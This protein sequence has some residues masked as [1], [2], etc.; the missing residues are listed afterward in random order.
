MP[1]RQKLRNPKWHQ[2]GLTLLESLIALLVSAL[3][4]LGVIGVQMRTLS[5]TQTSVRR[6]QSIRMIEDLSERM[7]VNPNAMANMSKYVSDWSSSLPTPEA[8][9]NCAKVVCT[10]S[11][12]AAYDLAEWKRFVQ[13]ALPS[14]D[15]NVF[16]AKGETD[17]TDRRQLGVMIRWRENEKSKDADYLA[18]INVAADGGDV[19]CGDGYTCHLQYIPVSSR[20]APFKG[21]STLRYFCPGA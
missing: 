4:I 16:I 10:A 11:E 1:K 2:Q 3:G 12:L 8:S 15:A 9:P 21:G 6:E 14:G 19:S 17:A 13:V 5:D 18:S 20:C 7:K